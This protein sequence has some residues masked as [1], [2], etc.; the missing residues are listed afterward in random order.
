MKIVDYRNSVRLESV[1]AHPPVMARRVV[2]G[3]LWG[4]VFA[5]MAIGAVG[6]ALLGSIQ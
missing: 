6:G 4:Y 5:M 1:T 2:R 3:V